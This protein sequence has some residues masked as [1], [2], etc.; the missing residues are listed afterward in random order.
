MTAV[1]SS[2]VLAVI[3]KSVF[4]LVVLSLFLVVMALDYLKLNWFRNLLVTYTSRDL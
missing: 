1:V 4:D 2:P 3:I